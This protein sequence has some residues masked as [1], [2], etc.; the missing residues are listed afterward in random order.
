MDYVYTL[1]YLLLN[2]FVLRLFANWPY[3][4]LVRS[5]L[6]ES[7]GHFFILIC[8][9]CG[10]KYSGF[11]RFFPEVNFDI[12]SFIY[13]IFSLFFSPSFLLCFFL[14]SSHIYET[15]IACQELVFC[16]AVLKTQTVIT[17]LPLTA[18]SS[19]S[20]LCSTTKK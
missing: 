13:L 6:P 14:P 3:L 16:N 11:V 2:M 7:R 1:L 15:M 19:S 10:L 4:L 20:N 5:K 9:F 18:L 8:C 12:H 17:V